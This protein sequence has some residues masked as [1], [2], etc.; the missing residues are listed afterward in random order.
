M[1]P[2][3]T[4][5]MPGGRGSWE[6]G[7]GTGERG[8]GCGASAR[9][10]CLHGLRTNAGASCFVQ[11]AWLLPAVAAALRACSTR[12]PAAAPLPPPLPPPTVAAAAVARLPAGIPMLFANLMKDGRIVGWAQTYMGN[13]EGALRT[14]KY[15]E[16]RA[17]ARTCVARPASRPGGR[18]ARTRPGP[19]A[20]PAP[21]PAA[22]VAAR[23][24]SLACY[25]A[26]SMSDD[27]LSVA[28]PC[29]SSK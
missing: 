26:G 16:E 5:V 11:T 2:G 17:R 19:A 29:S 7:G 23:H 13:G 27:P 9:L 6:D 1:A 24:A 4:F 8:T 10:V 28:G 12:R 21:G 15:G 18:R 14:A 20:A 22:A 3:D 25:A